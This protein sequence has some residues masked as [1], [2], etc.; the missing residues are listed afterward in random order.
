MT[1][2]DYSPDAMERHLSKQAAIADW[3]HKTEQYDPAN[4][5][6]PIP[7]EHPPSETFYSPPSPQAPYPS[8]QYQ[9]PYQT[10]HAAPQPQQPYPAYYAM[11]NGVISPT[12]IA[13]GSSSSRRHRKHHHSSSHHASGS[14]SLRPSPHTSHSALPLMPN[15][16]SYAPVP[17]RSVS[18]PPS[19]MNVPVASTSGQSFIGYQAQQHQLARPL[20]SPPM[21]TMNQSSYPFTYMAPQVVSPPFS[22]SSSHTIYSNV[23]AS[24]PSSSHTKH[25]YSKSYSHSQHG[26]NSHPGPMPMQYAAQAVQSSMQPMVI[27]YNGGYVVMP[28]G[29]QNVQYIVS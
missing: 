18:T 1:E 12:Y 2:Y 8:I 6:V 22:R 17:Q 13:G 9:Y 23:P 26:Y 16:F 7:G 28:G 21:M 10:P 14:K 27:P 25:S 15:G 11:P 29:S 5:F 20:A 19:V 4:P 24:R 3:V